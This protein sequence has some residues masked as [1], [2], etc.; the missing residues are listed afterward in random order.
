MDFKR[1]ELT[2]QVAQTAKEFALQKIKPHVMEWD[3]AQ[4]FPV[5]I[6]KEMG[7]LGLMGVFIPEEYGGAGLG[8]FEYSEIIQQI[9]SLRLYRPFISST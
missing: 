9:A 7:K 3:E 4:I 1:S 8:Y 6:F 2:D 5:E